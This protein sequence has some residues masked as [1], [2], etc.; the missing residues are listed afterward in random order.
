MR[1]ALV[2]HRF[3]PENLGGVETHTWSLARALA[4][5]LRELTDHPEQLAAMQANI[6]LQ[7]PCQSMP[8]TCCSSTKR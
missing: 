2:V 8:S 1:S 6:A 3:L 7:L 5:V 4:Q